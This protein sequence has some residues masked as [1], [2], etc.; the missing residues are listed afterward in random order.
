MAFAWKKSFTYSKYLSLCSQ[1]VRDALKPELRA[2]SQARST[3]EFVYSKWKDGSVQYTKS[4][5]P[6]EEENN[7]KEG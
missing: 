7:T 1:A 2:Q 3:V 5:T 6:K 4:G